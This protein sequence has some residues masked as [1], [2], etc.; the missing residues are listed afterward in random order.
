MPAPALR[1]AAAIDALAISQVAPAQ[2]TAGTIRLPDATIPYETHGAGTPVVFIHGYTQNMRIWDEQIAAFAPN[3]RVI[4]YDVR[5]FG[6]STGDVDGTSAA[7]D[8]ATLL[9]SLRIPRAAVVGLSMGARIALNFAVN[10]PDRVT[11]LV[12]YGA[13]P[14]ADFPVPE[15]PEMRALFARLPEIAKTYGPDSVLVAVHASELGWMPPGNAEA[16]RKARRGSEGYNARDLTHPTK[17]SG[18]VPRTTMAQIN[19]VRIP[20]LLIHGDHEVARFRQFND[21]LLAR[22]PNA[23]RVV[24][25]NAGHGAHFSEPEKFN[26]ALLDFLARAAPQ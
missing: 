12:L 16:V 10:Y 4:R 18:R 26:R 2:T 17:P 6:R 23:R 24:I 19:S 25:E 8:L 9:D 13:P 1:F 7:S 5:G 21:T 22:L 11:A 15:S 3:Y 20:V 14:T